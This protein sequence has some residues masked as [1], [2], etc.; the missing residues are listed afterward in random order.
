MS[1][2]TMQVRNWVNNI[3][4]FRKKDKRCSELMGRIKEIGARMT[5][6]YGKIHNEDYGSQDEFNEITFEISKLAEER[7]NKEKEYKGIME[8]EFGEFKEKYENIYELAIGEEGI[9]KQTLNNVLQAVDLYS[10][11]KI[12]HNQGTNMGLKYMQ[13]KFKMPENFFNYLPT[14]ENKE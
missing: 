2:G 3:E 11:Q 1:S 10:Q 7:R 8:A 4:K 13:K 9:D 6:L 14:D 5:D 12:N